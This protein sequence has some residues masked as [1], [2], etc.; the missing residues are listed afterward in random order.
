MHP[1]QPESHQIRFKLFKQAPVLKLLPAICVGVAMQFHHDYHLFTLMSLMIFSVSGTIVFSF[2]H[3]AF[4][5]SHSWLQ[6]FFL[7]ILLAAF[8]MFLV[9]MA[10]LRHQNDFFEKH[11]QGDDLILLKIEEAPAVKEKLISVNTSIIRLSNKQRDCTVSGKLSVLL[12]RKGNKKELHAGDLI[13]IAK[14]PR[15]ILNTSNPGGFDYASQQYMKQVYHSV[16][17]Y[18]NEFKLVGHAQTSRWKDV[19][20]KIKAATLK[21]LEKYIGQDQ[22]IIG[23]AEALLIGYKNNLDRDISQ[24]YANTGVVHIIAISG[25][26]LGLIY[27]TLLWFLGWIPWLNKRIVVRGLLLLLCLWTF[28][29]LSGASASVLR[30]AVMFTCIIIG[31]MLG[32]NA[33]IYNSLATSALILICIQPSY[34]F[35]IGFQL[36]YLAIIGILWLQQPIQ[37]IFRPKGFLLKK[38]WEMSSITLAAQIMAFPICI[39]YFHQFPN[40]FLPANLI[41]V[42]LSTVILFAEI[43]LLI[44]TPIPMAAALIGQ[45]CHTLIDILNDIIQWISHLPFSSLTHLQISTTVM[46]ILYLS[47]T[48]V[49]ATLIYRG[50]I[51]FRC[52]LASIILFSIA[53]TYDHNQTSNQQLLLVYNIKGASGI[54]FIDGQ[55]GILFADSALVK[56]DGMMKQAVGA[57]HDFLRVKKQNAAICNLNEKPKMVKTKK[58]TILLLDGRNANLL[59]SDSLSTDIIVVSNAST[60]DFMMLKNCFHPRVVVLDGTNPMWK[61]D[62]LRR[63]IEALNLQCFSVAEQGAYMLKLS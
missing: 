38:I 2:F 18:P 14:H 57:C 49:S 15:R 55:N 59:K 32:R 17:L 48:S 6:F 34:L 46:I 20:E 62:N 30:S 29:L 43:F 33:S 25:L 7:Q 23:I 37:N 10:D 58:Q 8:G 56:S 53:V 11:L 27:A 50:R 42:P 19:I 44:A 21:N 39:Y 1:S 35:D 5:Y 60:L 26:H 28:T 47:V 31:N 40:Y 61:I 52:A 45:I 13:F 36:S 51:I 63:K 41:A 3:T 12:L 16:F 22:E 4:H 9:F 24:S 54:E